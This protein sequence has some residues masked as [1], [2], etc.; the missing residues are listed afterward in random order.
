MCGPARIKWHVGKE[1]LLRVERAH[2]LSYKRYV[3]AH[4]R[5]AFG[6][7]GAVND[8]GY[9]APRSES[10]RT[11][12]RLF[13]DYTLPAMACCGLTALII[14]FLLFG[15]LELATLFAPSA[16]DPTVRWLL[17]GCFAFGVAAILVYEIVILCH[18]LHNKR[19]ANLAADGLQLGRGFISAMEKTP[20]QSPLAPVSDEQMAH[21]PHTCARCAA[22]KLDD[23]MDD[24]A[25]LLRGKLHTTRV[26][27]CALSSTS[28]C[29]DEEQREEQR[30]LLLCQ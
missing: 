16:S 18:I 2:L 17:A 20:H 10:S 28:A 19:Q 4:M 6:A 3:E 7:R 15:A 5:E 26:V 14:L 29:V 21:V 30:S 8:G 25:K 11:S 23:L 1:S 12:S 13:S 24:R 22:Y 9:H 27:P